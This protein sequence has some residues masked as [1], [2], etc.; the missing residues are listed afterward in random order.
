MTYFFADGKRHMPLARFSHWLLYPRTLN[1]M[2]LR[3]IL[4][5]TAPLLLGY[6]VESLI[7]HNFQL[8]A[9]QRLPVG[10]TW[11]WI[12]PFAPN[13]N[14]MNYSLLHT[15]SHDLVGWD[16]HSSPQEPPELSHSNKLTTHRSPGGIGERT[17][18]TTGEMFYHFLVA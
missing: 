4:C 1:T 15:K 17:N 9:E 7:P 3:L 8:V 2:I 16:P 18:R 12:G 5:I 14:E 11:P 13:S 10:P 6:Y